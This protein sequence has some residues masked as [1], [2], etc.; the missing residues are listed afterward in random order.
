MDQASMP[1]GRVSGRPRQRVPVDAGD[2]RRQLWLELASGG[3]GAAL[4]LFMWGHMLLVGSILTGAR[5][6]DWVAGTLEDYFIAQPTVAAVLAL[7][8]VHALLA[9]RK[10]PTRL[11]ERRR[12][13]ALARGLRPPPLHGA[14]GEPG[15]PRLTPHL[16]SLLW[17]WQVR[18]GLVV[19]VLGSF[20]VL[21][22]ALDV[23][24]PMFGA[25]TGIEAATSMARVAGG[26][27]PLYAV[28]LLCVEFHAGVGLFRLAL[29]W[30]AG[31]R[32]GRRLLHRLEL[33]VLVVFLGV[34]VLALAVL[35]G[36][37]APPFGFLLGL[38][39]TVGWLA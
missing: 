1:A 36:W 30:G 27:W 25:R 9:A 10:L 3:C 17:I 33:A 28:L 35:A 6:F 14:G 11:A 31:A 4:A 19:L 22:L 21:L 12:M 23:L 20:H 29:K 18:T 38:G 15:D 13:L 24:T 39:P 2:A 34:G 5:G 8:V 32:I 7:F 37:L 16:D 26:L